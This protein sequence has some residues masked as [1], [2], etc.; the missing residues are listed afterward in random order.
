MKLTEQIQLKWN[1]DISKLCHIAKNLYNKANYIIRQAFFNKNKWIRYNKLYYLIKNSDNY[2][3]L[4][5]QTS[6]QILKIVDNNWSS[7]FKSMKEYKK[8][9]NKFNNR[10]KPPKY[11]KKNGE[12]LLIFTNQQC[13]IKDGYLYLPKKCNLNPIKT[14]IDNKLHQVRIIPKGIIYV[15][16]II[17]E[18]EEVNLNLDK[19]R[20]LGVDIGVNNLVTIADSTSCDAYAVKGG[21]VK[22]INQLYNKLLSNP[23][24]INGCR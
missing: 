4:P 13:K 10:P 20:V 5:P 11:K 22:S 19:N 16:E 1:R 6:Q 3:A 12:F 17:Y 14:R 8:N 21:V 24:G 9:K 23:W 15:L 7:F 2:K 18:K